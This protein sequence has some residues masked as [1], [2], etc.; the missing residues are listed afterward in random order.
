MNAK[1]PPHN[2]EAEQSVLGAM[3]L[4]NDL[5]PDVVEIL[6]VND[7][8]RKDHAA[9]YGIMV[10]LFNKNMPIDVVTVT[11]K[12]SLSGIIEKV[13]GIQYIASLADMVPIASNARQYAAIVSEKSLQRRLINAAAEISATA[14]EPDGE[15]SDVLEMSEKIIF[16]IAQNRSLKSYVPVKDV[17]NDVF[18]KLENLYNSPESF[19]GIPTGFIDLDNKLSGLHKSDLIL[20]ASRPA[21]GKTAFMLNIAQYISIK[22]N[23][24]VALFNL[25]MSKEQL[26]QRILSSEAKVENEK[27][28][29]GKLAD[30]DWTKLA[31]VL[32]PISE[33]PMY[34]DD[35]TDVSIASI[36]AKCRKMKLEKN[37]GLVIIDYLQLMQGKGKE[38]RVQEVSEISRSLKLMARELDI[39]II[40]GSQL[41]RAV[42]S[43]NDKRPMLSDLRDS[44]AIEQDADIVMFLYREDYYNPETE[45]KNISEIIIAKHRNG[46]VGTIKLMFQPEST[47]FK[48]LTIQN[49]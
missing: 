6:S 45:F 10:D 16:N 43:R 2:I 41:S 29:T 11:D 12:L 35:S 34:F 20:V 13:G 22:K 24:P 7:F 37:I 23:I 38:N 46:S 44:G 18:I 39:P 21:M 28:K 25:E 19:S 42:E 32:G 15:V 4:N 14:Y 9:I 26:V 48:N 36:R 27:L 8:Y 33:A 31:S 49:R 30:Q 17:L 3:L 5:I 47:T 40:V 1:I